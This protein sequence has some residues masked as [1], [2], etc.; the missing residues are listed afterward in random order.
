MKAVKEMAVAIEDVHRAVRDSY[1]YETDTAPLPKKRAKA[2][3]ELYHELKTLFPDKDI[4]VQAVIRWKWSV[5]DILN[6]W[7][8]SVKS[9]VSDNE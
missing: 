4:V 6:V 5:R 7:A 2:D 8:N 9:G 3:E 1:H